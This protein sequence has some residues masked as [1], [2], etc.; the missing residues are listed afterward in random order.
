LTPDHKSLEN[1]GQ[2]SSDLGILYI[3]EI[4][5]LRAIIDSPP[6]FKTKLI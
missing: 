4:I 3:V 2:M 5:F 6:I 1:R